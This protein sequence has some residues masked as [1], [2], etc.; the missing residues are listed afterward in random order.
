MYTHFF[1]GPI[2]QLNHLPYLLPNNIYIYIRKYSNTLWCSASINNDDETIFSV[3]PTTC[4]K[5]YIVRRV[6]RERDFC[7]CNTRT[8]LFP[9]K[10]PRTQETFEVRRDRPKTI[11]KYVAGRSGFKVFPNT[12]VNTY[13]FR[14]INADCVA[15]SNQIRHEL[16]RCG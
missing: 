11:S 1:L 8:S 14:R 15:S 5:Y 3:R 9:R 16:Q 2:N 6:R 12:V 10:I 7:A 13:L 4:C